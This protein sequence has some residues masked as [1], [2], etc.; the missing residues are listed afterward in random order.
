MRCDGRAGGAGRIATPPPAF[1][2]A[3]C[4]AGILLMP[5]ASIELQ[6]ICTARPPPKRCAASS[7]NAL[8][9]EVDEPRLCGG[10]AML[11]DLVS[12]ERMHM[13]DMPAPQHA[14]VTAGGA[15]RPCAKS[16]PVLS[17]SGEEPMYWGFLALRFVNLPPWHTEPPSR[18]AAGCKRVPLRS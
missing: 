16:G 13:S 3:N 8:G 18:G 14:D 17:A 2:P 12:G 10:L 5:F 9:A 1:A 7:R 6:R 11:L 4:G 15:V